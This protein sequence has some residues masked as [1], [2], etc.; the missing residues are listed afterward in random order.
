M[1]EFSILLV[2]DN[3]DFLNGMI[4]NL[5][6][7]FP[8]R[9]II[10]VLSGKEALTVLT[11]QHVGVMLSDLRMPG[12]SGQELLQETKKI[13]PN[14]CV[15][16]IT[17]HG[18]V[19]TAVK[20]LKLGAW[21]FLTKPVERQALY[22][23]VE[24][25]VEH[26][27]LSNENKRLIKVIKDLKTGRILLGQSPV[28]QQ[29]QKQVET[30]AATDYTVLITGESG[31]GKE[32]I[33]RNIHT[34][35]KRKNRS[36]HAL[37]CPTIPKGL[38]ESELFG[39]VR[40][41]FTGADRDRSG[42][43][44]SADKGTLI[45]DEIGDIAP[46]IQAKLLKFLQDKEVKP[47]GSSVSKQADV[48]IIA[49]TNQNLEEKI[50]SGTFREDLYYRLNVL[51]V[52]VPP[53]RDRKE[54]IPA[55][56]RKFI[57]KSCRE[58]DVDSM[59]IDPTALGYLA[60]Q[61]WPGNVRELLNYVRRLVVFSNGNTIDLP[62]IRVVQGEKQ[63]CREETKQGTSDYKEAKKEALDE[64][65]R[66]YL[67]RIFENTRGN[68]SQASRISG[69]ERASIQKIVKRLEIDMS[70]YRD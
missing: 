35:S 30:I 23:T 68:I 4:R 21:D 38:L 18:T 2:D 63:P 31:S 39:H 19:E 15:I 12:I 41:A 45:L 57:L 46:A 60:G 6:K 66:S 27:G 43:F 28:M 17:G 37:N 49:L 44:M 54:D 5:K 52:T 1:N 13:N 24:R 7:K 70:Q 59:D 53:L 56:V 9:Q 61:S 26:Y 62:L 55:L 69:L 33:A 22:H 25:A 51:S 10:G 65:A 42:F 14:I 20:S 34:F 58:L 50:R 36:C 16:M 8:D 64:F 29:L 3:K 48:R 32:F 11:D 47:V 67:H 40:G